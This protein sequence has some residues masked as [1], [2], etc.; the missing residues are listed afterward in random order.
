M[1]NFLRRVRLAALLVLLMLP[2]FAKAAGEVEPG[3]DEHLG[4]YLPLNMKFTDSKGKEVLLKDLIDKPTVIDFVYYKCRGICTPLMTEV[5]DV[6]NRVNMEPGTDYNI[7]SISIDENET[8]ADAAQKKN[9]MMRLV[10]RQLPDSSWRFLTGDSLNIY[11]L[12]KAAGFKFERTPGGFLHKGVLI[13]VSKD[14]KICRYLHPGFDRRGDFRILPY[15]FKMALIYSQKGEAIPGIND[16]L[17]VCFSETPKNESMVYDIFKISG[18]G[19]ILLVIGFVIYINGK[20]KK[21]KR[22]TVS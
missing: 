12:T 22:N 19:V 21:E 13:F 14:G 3:V 17:R 8:P 10:G 4:A 9:T 16:Q 15:K 6:I 5:A 2:G 7:V 1:N 18:A 11:K 20:S